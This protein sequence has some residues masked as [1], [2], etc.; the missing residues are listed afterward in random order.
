MTTVKIKPTGQKV[1]IK[2]NKQPA[3]PV[4]QEKGIISC[5]LEIIQSDIHKK[6]YGEEK[7]KVKMPESKESWNDWK[8]E[9]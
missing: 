1:T 9:I 8:D 7:R 4:Q 6:I 2:V 3:P 5:M